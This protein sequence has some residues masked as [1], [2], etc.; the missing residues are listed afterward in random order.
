MARVAERF[1]ERF[2]VPGLGVA[3]ARHGRM[4]YEE[5]FG[6]AI[7]ERRVA[8][9][10][11]SLFR[12]ASVTK[13]IT[14]VAIF[15]LIERNRLRLGD[16][17]FGSGGVLGTEFGDPSRKRFVPE[18]TVE[19]LLTHTGGGWPNDG[20]DPMFRNPG[21]SHAQ[22]IAW[23]IADL[24][25][26]NPPGS[27]FAYSNFGYCVL[28]RVIERVARRPYA[29]YVQ[30]AVLARCG[31][32]GMRIAGN[33]AHERAPD[34]VAYYDQNGE[35][36]YGMNVARMDSHGGWLASAG[37]LVRFANHV[38]GFGDASPVLGAA[39]IRVMTTATAANAGYAKGWAVN[40]SHNWWHNGSLPGTSTIMVRTASGLCWA[41][42]TNT[43]RSGDIDG[44]LD[45][46]M[47]DFVRCVPAWQA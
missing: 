42:L 39:T 2:G 45:S 4:V 6:Q 24:P 47:W 26:A 33:T 10:P 30:E 38:D 5:G 16:R 21:M 40:T 29:A 35:D 17:V 41:A 37:D 43:R 18:I 25:L 20:T 23:A 7:R 12:I 1:M 15:S 44:A 9:T 36:P 28:G 34:E 32:S 46:M 14:S 19:H 11:R 22:L 27:H 8:V 3:V 31:I 13:P